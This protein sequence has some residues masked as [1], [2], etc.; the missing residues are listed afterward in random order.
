MDVEGSEAKANAGMANMLARDRPH[1]MFECNPLTMISMGG[2]VAELFGSLE[3]FGYSFYRV[4][5]L[6]GVLAPRDGPQEVLV[7]DYLATTMEPAELERITQAPV[8]PLTPDELLGS[9]R[10]YADQTDI[11][12]MF[13]AMS[14]ASFPAMPEEPAFSAD[15]AEWHRQFNNDPTYLALQKCLG[16][17]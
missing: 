11:H 17:T 9:F 4:V 15:V 12:R 14:K 10:F 8:R 6:F 3:R 5:D 13:A 2:D 7:A 16:L 1:I